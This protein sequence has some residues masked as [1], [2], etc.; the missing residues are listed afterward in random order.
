MKSASI[1]IGDLE[2]K[3]SSRKLNFMD[4]PKI[5]YHMLTRI[6]ALFLFFY[7]VFFFIFWSLFALTPKLIA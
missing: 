4:A 1:K 7:I 5:K 2:I 3:S 6:R